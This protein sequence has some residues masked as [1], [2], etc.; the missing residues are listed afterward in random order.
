MNAEPSENRNP[1]P[2]SVRNSLAPLI[3]RYAMEEGVTETQYPGLILGRFNR[4]VPRYP[5]VYSPSVC[6]VAQ[7]RKQVYSANERV[8]YDP[9][10]YLVV[11]L[12]LPLEAEVV[13]ASPK[14]PFLALALEIDMS[15]IGKLLLEMAEEEQLEEDNRLGKSIYTS[16]M[17]EDLLNAVKRL[18]RALETP[19]TR[20]ILGPGAVWEILYHVLKG[21]QG[22]FLRSIVLRNG[23][24]KSIMRVVRYLQENYNKQHNI[25]S[26]ARYA[27]MSK[28]TLQ[29]VFKRFVDQ[30]PI[31]Y[32][33]KIR[34][35]QAR[36][37]IVGKGYNASDAAHEVGYNSTSQFSREFKRL[38]GLPPSRSAENLQNE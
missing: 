4:P 7:G 36:L 10:H 15:M 9:L 22:A 29:H 5:L 21:E 6:V 8:V 16:N 2:V 24:S 25:N 34:L 37:M 20:R 17:N 18:L 33:K 32:L 28:S 35:H 31:Q 12:P 30:S 1:P 11:A 27:G 14:R 38:F 23:G 3:E 19:V 26:I 13:I